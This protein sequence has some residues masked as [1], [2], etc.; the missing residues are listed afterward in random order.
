M[1]VFKYKA[2]SPDQKTVTGLVEAPTESIAVDILKDKQL[3]IIAFEEQKK[4]TGGFNIVLDK[5]KAKD[6]VI[7]SR[8]FSVLVSA[9]VALVQSL[10]LLT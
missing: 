10:H 7:F 6:V 8:Q 4:G 2:V 5:I 1:S 3:T 9:N